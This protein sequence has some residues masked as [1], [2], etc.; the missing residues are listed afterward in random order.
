MPAAASAPGK[1]M[2]FGEHAVVYG[3]P[4][5]VTA[6]DL[7][8]SVAVERVPASTVAVDTPV[9]RKYG[10]SFS[11]PME[12]IL[13]QT[14]P[15][16]AAAF[17]LAAV[18]CFHRQYPFDGGLTIQTDGPEVSY[19][20]GS[21][22]AVTVATV[23]ALAELFEVTVTGREMYTMALDAVLEVQ[24]KGS[25]FD[26]AAATFGG[27]LYFEHGGKVIESLEVP[28]LPIVIGF[29]GDKVST[30]NLIEQVAGL[31]ERHPETVDGIFDVIHEIVWHAKR[32]LDTKDWAGLGDLMNINQGLL[33]ALGVSTP[34]LAKQIF[35]ARKAGAFGAK[36]SGAGGGD[37]MFAMVDAVK[38]PQVSEAI[39]TAGGQIVGIKTGVDGV[40]IEQKFRSQP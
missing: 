27:T 36:L 12:T 24:G 8:Y 4:C 23:A 40:R 15:P 7:R 17:V 3:F 13:G 22:S 39:E 38:K 5:I 35:A 33:D 25:G 29:S 31:R 18:K 6:V 37:C 16:K 21:S 19:G 11:A 9:M 26:V 32:F 34:Q 1:L 10:Q 14:D 28:E 30:T 2:L 20:L